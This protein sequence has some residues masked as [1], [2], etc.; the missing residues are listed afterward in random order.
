MTRKRVLLLMDFS[1]WGYAAQRAVL[2]MET[3]ERLDVVLLVV[4]QPGR[5]PASAS[6]LR[7]AEMMA[8]AHASR[9][10]VA[11]VVMA[12]DDTMR[13]VREGWC[14]G[15]DLVVTGENL[16]DWRSCDDSTAWLIVDAA[17][18]VS[19][20]LEAN[21]ASRAQTYSREPM[22]GRVMRGRRIPGIAA[23]SPI[24]TTIDAWSNRRVGAA[25]I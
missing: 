23:T 6:A 21:A 17:G 3:T 5:S 10:A 12:S 11:Q 9:G 14:E 24:E 20:R 18:Q 1:R 16:A 8:E 19:R 22:R 2:G 4:G 15:F 25:A 13:A 7:F